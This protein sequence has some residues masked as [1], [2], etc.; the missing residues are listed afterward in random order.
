[1]RATPFL[2]LVTLLGTLFGPVK[3]AAADEADEFFELGLSYLRTAF[4]A[5]ARAAFAE[6]LVR[7]PGQAVPTAFAGIGVAAEGRDSRSCAY[8]LRLAYERMPA[9]RNLR[10][11]LRNVMRSER[12]L[13]PLPRTDRG[14]QQQSV[15]P[16]RPSCGSTYS[17]TLPT[18]RRPPEFHVPERSD[19]GTGPIF[20]SLFV[21][22]LVILRGA[23]RVSLRVATVARRWKTLPLVHHALASVATTMRQSLSYNSL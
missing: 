21:W 3:Q 5:D 12:D 23:G 17:P 2:L 20:G 1:M 9:R 15:S 16:D 10:L 18:R 4:Y 7:A 14:P 22:G 8:L 6:S 19:A 13:C 11:D